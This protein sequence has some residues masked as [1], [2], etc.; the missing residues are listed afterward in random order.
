[1]NRS[2]FN[3][4]LYEQQSHRF[5]LKGFHLYHLRLYRTPVGLDIRDFHPYFII[6]LKNISKPRHGDDRLTHSYSE[7]CDQATIPILCKDSQIS[8]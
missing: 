4:V 2:F 5:H 1:M 7:L 6:L 3:H 8:T